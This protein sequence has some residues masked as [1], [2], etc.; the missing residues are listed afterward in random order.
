MQREELNAET[1]KILWKEL[2]KFF[3]NGTTI[4]VSPDLDLIDVAL[5][6]CQD[7]K[8]QMEQWMAEGRVG[9]VSD[10]KAIEWMEAETT[11]WSVVVKPWVLVQPLKAQPLKSSDS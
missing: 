1:A 6:V 5:E 11:V 9:Q 8:A 2:E 10:D 7:N 4:Y 3:A